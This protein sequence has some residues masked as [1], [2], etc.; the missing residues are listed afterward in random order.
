[1]RLNIKLKLVAVVFIALT[2]SSPISVFIQDLLADYVLAHLD[3][4]P[5]S[6]GVYIN[7]I[8]SMLVTI[9]LLLTSV[10][11]IVLKPMNKLKDSMEKVSKGDLKEELNIKTKDELGVLS[12]YYNDMINKTS[13]ILLELKQEILELAQEQ[14]EMNTYTDKI[15][16]VSENVKSN[17]FQSQDL[18]NRQK[19]IIV[20]VS[21][22]LLELSSLVQVSKDK[23]TKSSEVLQNAKDKS[24]GGVKLILDT[25]NKF[26]EMSRRI[27]E[28]NKDMKE[29][30]ISTE[31][32]NNF[33]LLIEKIAHQTSLLSLNAS[34]EA[35]RAGEHG[36]GFAVVADEIGQL[37]NEV[38]NILNKSNAITNNITDNVKRVVDTNDNNS[39]E[40]I[41]GVQT[42][43]IVTDY[44]QEL[45]DIVLN[46]M[47]KSQE[48]KSITAEEVASSEQIIQFI[49]K[50]RIIAEDNLEQL[51][52][53]NTNIESQ[54]K[55][56]KQISHKS[57]T[58]NISMNKLA[59]KIDYFKLRK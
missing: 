39:K 58:I 10:N 52:K 37:A 8:I 9:G 31:E 6:M 32:L 19:E 40:L 29:L 57:D 21:Q 33:M 55:I 18:I 26:N 54:N 56:V 59:E 1:M 42:L 35:A 34:I 5:Q 43:N 45:E 15:E 13:E 47:S 51:I 12:T 48:I 3:F 7:Y 22:T 41:E 50:L 20:D 46:A 27:I 4:I 38:V 2:I 30:E 24:I 23:A 53:T 11:I 44:F 49:D 16:E 14:K 17:S 25:E 36:K 28:S